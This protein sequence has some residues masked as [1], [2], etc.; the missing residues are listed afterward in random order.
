MGVDEIPEKRKKIK[1]QIEF[2]YNILESQKR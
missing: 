1:A 2:R